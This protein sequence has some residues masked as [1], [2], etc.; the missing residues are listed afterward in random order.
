VDNIWLIAD[1]QK[2]HTISTCST[3]LDTAKAFL[4]GGI[5]HKV[6]GH[7]DFPVIVVK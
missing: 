5:A 1:E 7:A 3:G 6:V 4:L 2:A